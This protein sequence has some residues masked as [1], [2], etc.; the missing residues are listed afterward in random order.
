M[1]VLRVRD[2][3]SKDVG[4]TFESMMKREGAQI[5]SLLLSFQRYPF[6]KTQMLA[7]N[8]SSCVHS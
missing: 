1:I 7:F 3:Q 2:V 8:S 6:P 5:Y 4:K